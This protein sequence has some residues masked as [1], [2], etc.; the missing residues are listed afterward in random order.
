[1]SFVVFAPCH[2]QTNNVVSELVRHKPDGHRRWL[3]AG[4]FGFNLESKGIVL[5]L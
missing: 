4:N 5:S 2:E 1:M 3:E